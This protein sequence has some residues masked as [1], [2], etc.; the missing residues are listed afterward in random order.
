MDL[1]PL[2]LTLHGKTNANVR[3]RHASVR[4]GISWDA[5]MR[6]SKDSGRGFRS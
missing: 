1:D 4:N 2:R 6:R 5:W 3:R